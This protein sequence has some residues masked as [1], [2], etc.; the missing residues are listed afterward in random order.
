MA[1]RARWFGV[2]IAF[3]ALLLVVLYVWWNYGPPSPVDPALAA[4]GIGSIGWIAVQ[5]MVAGVVT[6][7]VTALARWALPPI[8][9]REVG[10]VAVGAV[11]A[12]FVSGYVTYLTAGPTTTKG[13][14]IVRTALTYACV[15]LV[16]GIWIRRS[17]RRDAGAQLQRS[18]G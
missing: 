10:C 6:L 5:A 3:A 2:P 13:D 17:R 15:L 9:W 12:Q 4:T 1:H 8:T 11:V 16:S 18:S 14:E 7:I